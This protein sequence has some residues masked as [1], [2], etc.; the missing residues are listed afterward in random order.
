MFSD[1]LS[2][3]RLLAA[4][5]SEVLADNSDFTESQ[6]V[7]VGLPRGG[8]PIAAEIACHL[9][10]PID[11]LVSKKMR[12]PDNPELAIGAVASSGVVVLDERVARYRGLRASYEEAQRTQEAQL[13]QETK[14]QERRWLE[15]A[16]IKVRPDWRG[17]LVILTD[18]GIATGMTTRAALE[19]AKQRQPA[20]IWL[21]TPVSPYDTYLNLQSQCSL[22]V[23]L[24]TPRDFS[25][26]GSFYDD[27]HQ[28]EDSEVVNTL[29]NALKAVS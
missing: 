2:A 25:A 5:L 18:D 20:A 19:T 27:F 14:E 23:A 3:G 7:V 21:A 11:I 13:I 28:V 12:A 9:K 26:V 10:C 15:L 4:R 29:R 22:F 24:L 8:V 17:K 16:D 1:R 6:T